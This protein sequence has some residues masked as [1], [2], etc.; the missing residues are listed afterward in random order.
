MDY[1]IKNNQEL[2]K[3]NTEIIKEIKELEKKLENLEN[4]NDEL[5]K[6][7]PYLRGLAI[8]EYENNKK[9]YELLKDLKK[10]R[11]VLIYQYKHFIIIRNWILLLVFLSP[12][13][14][15]LFSYIFYGIN[16]TFTINLFNSFIAIVYLFYTE[17]HFSTYQIKLELSQEIKDKWKE[18]TRMRENNNYLEQLVD[19]C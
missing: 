4:E 10:E 2:R 15:Y 9:L 13:L 18:Y 7:L 8:N 1:I 3:E 6:K 16:F 17:P 12:L 19:N 14:S 5:E 11:K